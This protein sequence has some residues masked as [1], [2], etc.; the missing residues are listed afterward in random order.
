MFTD[1]ERMSYEWL[2]AVLRVADRILQPHQPWQEEKGVE[3]PP[4]KIPIIPIRLT[5]EKKIKMIL[6]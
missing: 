4:L 1:T 5:R 6:L 2:N 3:P